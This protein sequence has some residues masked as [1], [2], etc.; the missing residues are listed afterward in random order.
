MSK[1]RFPKQPHDPGT[2]PF[3]GADGANPFADPEG[4]ESGDANPFAAAPAAAE[5]K[6]AEYVALLP[7]RGKLIW[8]CGA[9]GLLAT[10][11]GLILSVGL[12]SSAGSWTAGLVNSLPI[13]S[14][15]LA[16]A[17]PAW[18]LGH[19]DRRAIRAGAMDR[20]GQAPTTVGLRMGQVATFLALLPFVVLISSLWFDF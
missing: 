13:Q 16:L 6:P 1:F 2:R 17:L 10:T 14:I 5:Y 9:L 20:S 11:A 12:V 18:I 8:R 3:A 19:R 15:C 7:H 4:P